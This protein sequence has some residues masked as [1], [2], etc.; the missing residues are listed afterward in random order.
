MVD[1]GEYLKHF[2]VYKKESNNARARDKTEM[3]E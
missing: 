1:D 3:V 2:Q